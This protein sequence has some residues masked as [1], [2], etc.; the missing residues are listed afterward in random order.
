MKVEV[1]ENLLNK[2]IENLL[3][4]DSISDRDRNILISRNGLLN[5]KK[6]NTLESIGRDFGIT[7]ERI[8]QIE[9]N[10]INSLKDSGSL[11]VSNNANVVKLFDE[12]LKNVKDEGGLVDEDRFFDSY[13]ISQRKNNNIRNSVTFLIDL[14]D[15]PIERRKSEKHFNNRL[16][17]IRNREF[18]DCVE[19]ALKG[20]VKSINKDEIYDEKE[21]TNRFSECMSNNYS[22][23][24]NTKNIIGFLNIS[25]QIGMNN[26]KEWGLNKSPQIKLANVGDRAYLILRNVGEPLHFRTIANRIRYDLKCKIQ[27]TTCH[28]EL[29]KS[30]RFVLAGKGHYA[31]K[32]WG[33]KGGTVKDI[34]VNLLKKKGSLSYEDIEKGVLEQK[35]VNSGTIMN[36]LYKNRCFKKDK[37]GKYILVKC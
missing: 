33:Y 35:F 26:V 36:S 24:I 2:S 12:I 30:P 18:A 8:R 22:K 11:K 28:N 29:I 21:F 14:C 1:F 7:R 37:N 19:Y 23:R 20:L 34:I 31:L 25:N 17:D 10:A 27:D 32:D 9:K 3:N 4:S 6:K 15:G 5:S 16:V 13:F